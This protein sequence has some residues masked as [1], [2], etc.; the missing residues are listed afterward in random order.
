MPPFVHP[1]RRDFVSKVSD[2]LEISNRLFGRYIELNGNNMQSML[3]VF[4]PYISFISGYQWPHGDDL[5]SSFQLSGEMLN[6]MFLIQL[7][8]FDCG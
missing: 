3:N 1:E 5:K 6:R 4:S 7:E 2:F 8:S